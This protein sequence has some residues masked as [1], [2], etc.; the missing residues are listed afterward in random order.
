MLIKS[1]G[2]ENITKIDN[3]M[4]GADSGLDRPEITT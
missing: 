1:N 3:Y 2:I 4:V